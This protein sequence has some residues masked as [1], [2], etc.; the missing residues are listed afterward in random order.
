MRAKTLVLFVVAIGCGLIASIG[1]SRYLE[2]AS[3]STKPAQETVKIFV[4]AADINIG[5]KLTEQNVQMA[6]WP[7]DRLPD[8]AIK[9][10]K[11]LEQRFPRTR[12]YMGEPIL[13]A[14]LMDSNDGSKSVDIPKGYRVVSVKVSMEASV[15]GLVQ[16][17]DR[18]DLVVCLKKNQEIPETAS[19]TILRDVNVFAVD[20]ETE[21]RLDASGQT[22]IVRTVSLLVKPQQA[23]AVMLASELGQMYLT[24]R[25]P[26]DDHE[27]PASDG[28]T[29]QSLLGT[30]AES[31]RETKSQPAA[32]GGGFA[33]W[34]SN[35]AASAAQG[36]QLQVP[37]PVAAAEPAWTMR[38]LTPDGWREYRW[39]D[40]KE[41]PEEVSPTNSNGVG[42]AEIPANAGIPQIGL[43]PAAAPQLP[44]KPAPAPPN[45]AS[46]SEAA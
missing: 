1:V 20:T 28:V 34:L 12:L 29:L 14:K 42:S 3:G 43:P 2:R 22:R 46:R 6:D 30:D 4:A 13:R 25:R 21:R 37:S 44:D 24:L 38:V 18:V 9:D 26:D 17:G 23:E 11:D 31:A 35:A 27:L 32:A 5:E 41:L 8:G 36:V 33:Q 10:R 16:P 7:K 19:R 40:P 45:K 39:R 15:S